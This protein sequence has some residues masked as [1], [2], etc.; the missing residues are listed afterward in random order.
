MLDSE[1]DTLSVS[2]GGRDMLDYALRSLGL[3]TGTRVILRVEVVA[4]GVK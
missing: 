1:Y 2:E 3:T 4:P